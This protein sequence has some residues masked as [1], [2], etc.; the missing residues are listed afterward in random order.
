MGVVTKITGS[1]S[2]DK[3]TVT[4]T[5]I[6]NRNTIV[7]EALAFTGGL[8]FVN[9]ALTFVSPARQADTGLWCLSADWD[10]DYG[11][12]GKG[13]DVSQLVELVVNYG[14]PEQDQSSD[15]GSV[16]VE[17][18]GDMLQLQ[19]GAFRWSTGAKAG[20]L[21]SDE[22]DA[23][24]FIII[25]NATIKVKNNQKPNVDLAGLT[26][27]YG[28][29]NSTSLFL[30]GLSQFIPAGYVRFDGVSVDKKFTNDGYQFFEVTYTFAATSHKWNELFNGSAYAAV[31]PQLYATADLNAV[32]NS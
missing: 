24:P 4:E 5:Y 16:S 6:T 29:V 31:T 25:P 10:V 17:I 28:K 23:K 9:G 27:Y 21:L 12:D 8:Q 19:R 14:I 26:Y 7:A 22:D 32:F 18:G 3:P 2:R 11:S 13:N 1:F 30:P 15:L 20:K